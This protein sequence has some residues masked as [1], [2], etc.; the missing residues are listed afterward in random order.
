MML[1][2]S[3]WAAA[4]VVAFAGSAIAQGDK[5]M[6]GK[7]TAA[8]GGV[9]ET[10]MHHEQTMLESLQKGDV[11][12][13]KKWIAPGSWSVDEGGYMTIDDFVKSLTDSKTAFKWESFKT[14][15]MKVVDVAPT[16]KIVTYKLDQRGSF[17]GQPFPS[18][19]Y[20]STVW[21]NHGGTWHAVF[22][23]ES[24]AAKR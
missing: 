20:A 24:T 11:E 3:V 6:A 10:L 16:A 1:K 12:A 2:R 14:S 22:H 23:Q 17:N 4:L 5:K 19:V 18:P 8:M 21:V 13:F 7:P 15:D 9:N